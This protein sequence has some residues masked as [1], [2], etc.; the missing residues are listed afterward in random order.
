[1]NLPDT[2]EIFY[3]DLVPEAQAELLKAFGYVNPSEGN[4]DA[5]PLFV[6]VSAEE[7]HES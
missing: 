4:W 3:S 1:M 5:F 2:V 7:D 6:L